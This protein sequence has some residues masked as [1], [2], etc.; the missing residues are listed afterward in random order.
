MHIDQLKAFGSSNIVIC[1]IFGEDGSLKYGNEFYQRLFKGTLG[2]HYNKFASPKD[3]ARIQATCL[4]ARLNPGQLFT[5]SI[6]A[7]TTGH[8]WSVFMFEMFVCEDGSIGVAAVK[9]PDDILEDGADAD[10]LRVRMREIA[11]IQSHEFRPPLARILGLSDIIADS[12]DIAEIKSYALL[13]RSSAK[14]LDR[15][16]AEVIKRT[17]PKSDG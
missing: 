5:C 15:Q 9:V 12:N 3:H 13:M 17:N 10:M 4:Q 8:V 2:E 14:E 16:H 6:K 1:A 11:F 7:I